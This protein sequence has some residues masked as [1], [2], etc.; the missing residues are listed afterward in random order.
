MQSAQAFG[1]CRVPKCSGNAECPSAQAMQSAWVLWQWKVPKRLGN[2]QSLSTRAVESTQTLGQL[3]GLPE[4]L[5]NCLGCPSARAAKC[6]S[7]WAMHSAIQ[8]PLVIQ[9]TLAMKC[10]L[11]SLS[12]CTA[13]ALGQGA[14]PECSGTLHCPSTQAL[15]IARVV[16]HF[17]L[18]STQALSTAQEL[19]LPEHLGTLHFRAV[20]SARLLGQST[21]AKHSGSASARAMQS[22]WALWQC[23]VPEC[24][25]N[26]NWP[27]AQAM[28]SALPKCSVPKG[29]SSASACSVQCKVPKS[30]G[31]AK[32]TSAQT[33]ESAWPLR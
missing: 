1:Q 11:H 4:H 28:H 29:S 17:P 7:T 8:C 18:P 3:L 13:R 21:V 31:N 19:A 16:V 6:L 32:C 30:S 24:S 27:S 14:L 20:E 9:C 33:M 23:T 26:A 12:I 10:T 22:A 15:C 2:A 25:S 5:G